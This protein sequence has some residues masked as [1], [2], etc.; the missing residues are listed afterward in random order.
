VAGSITDEGDVLVL[1]LG[2]LPDLDLATA[3]HDTNTHGGQE[4][5]CGVGVVVDAAVEHGGG[6]LA[7]ARADQGTATRVVLDEVG[8]V[9]DDAGDGDQG[10]AVLGL[11]LVGVPVDDGQLLERDAPVKGLALLVELLLQLLQAAL[12][13]LVLLELLEVVGEAELLPGPDHPLGGVVLVPLDGVAVVGGELVVEVVVALSEGDQ[14]SDNVIARGVAVVEGLVAEPVGQR[15]DAEGGLLDEEDAQDA[16]VDEAA[17]PVAP[18]E[19]S[20]EAGEDQAHEDDG[21][22]VVAVLPDDDGVV[23]QVR[24]VGT[25]DALGVL[26]HDHPAEVRVEQALPDGVG[27]L[28]GVGV[29]VVGTMVS[30]PP[31]DGALDGATAHSCQEQLEG[32]GRRVRAVSPQPVIA[33]EETL[34]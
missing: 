14:C 20:D 13:D 11:L 17:L 26:L 2:A 30:R 4:V 29:A 10:A 34:A 1:A 31:A 6:V 8:H 28:V 23:V 9:V 27:V 3:A 24:D 25:A 7:D 33:W 15:V 12:L 16:G 32:S 21:L 19:A 18:A 5:V 22:D